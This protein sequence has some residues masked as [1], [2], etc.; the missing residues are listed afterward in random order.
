M[1]MDL[2][3]VTAVSAN[4][5]V[6][7]VIRRLERLRNQ[8]GIFPGQRRREERKREESDDDEEGFNVERTA[9]QF[10]N[11]ALV[12]APAVGGSNPPFSVVEHVRKFT[13]FSV[14][15]NCDG[16]LRQLEQ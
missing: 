9:L 5:A 4:G 7:L 12:L 6:R 16:H 8:S 3:D 11:A 14:G 13:V 15:D 10:S 2:N 1:M